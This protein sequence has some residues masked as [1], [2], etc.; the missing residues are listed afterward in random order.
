MDP[1]INHY[2]SLNLFDSMSCIFFNIL[3]DLK[4]NTTVTKCTLNKTEQQIFLF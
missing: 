2:K 3:F 1:I 4:E